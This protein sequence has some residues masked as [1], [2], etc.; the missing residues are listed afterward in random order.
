MMNLTVSDQPVIRAKLAQAKIGS[1]DRPPQ[2]NIKLLAEVLEQILNEN[3]E[4]FSN[5]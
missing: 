4:G 2:A 5:G 1:W 3:A